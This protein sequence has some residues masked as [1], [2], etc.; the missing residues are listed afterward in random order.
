MCSTVY[1]GFC[2]VLCLHECCVPCS[3]DDDDSKTPL[4][5]AAEAGH[6]EIVA[7]LLRFRKVQTYL[8]NQPKEVESASV[9]YCYNLDFVAV[10]CVI[11]VCRAV[12]ALR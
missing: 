3:D 6:D 1:L 11:I 4:L 10:H 2:L 8:K 12:S 9:S 7:Y 5:C